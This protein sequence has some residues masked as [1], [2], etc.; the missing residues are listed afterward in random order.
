[1]YVKIDLSDRVSFCLYTYK[2]ALV[3]KIVSILNRKYVKR[4]QDR[5]VHIYFYVY[6]IQFQ[7]VLYSQTTYCWSR[8]ALY[9]FAVIFSIKSITT[10]R[11]AGLQICMAYLSNACDSLHLLTLNYSMD[12][13]NFHRD[14]ITTTYVQKLQFWNQ[15]LLAEPCSYSCFLN[16]H[17]I[18]GETQFK[19]TFEDT[20]KNIKL[21]AATKW[22][23]QSLL[24]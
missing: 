7:I 11:K 5:S 1:M 4:N 15:K 2:N 17:A 10:V 8:W 9:H 14:A 20:R 23:V 22:Q 18:S 3:Q 13:C 12:K 6:S 16:L 24:S 19:E 21:F